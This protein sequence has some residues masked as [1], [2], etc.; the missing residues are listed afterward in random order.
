MASPF[1]L[2]TKTSET[3]E[4][5]TDRFGFQS[6]ATAGTVTPN[7]REGTTWGK[8]YATNKAAT[9]NAAN[10]LNYNVANRHYV[11]GATIFWKYVRELDDAN[12]SSFDLDVDT[13]S[14][15]TDIRIVDKVTI[16][17][18][19]WQNS[20]VDRDI[21]YTFDFLNASKNSLG[22]NTWIIGTSGYTRD[23][24]FGIDKLIKKYSINS[25]DDSKNWASSFTQ[26]IIDDLKIKVTY[27]EKGEG[28]GRAGMHALE[29]IVE[30]T[31][32]NA[33]FFG[34]VA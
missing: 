25:A 4:D 29:V 11:D 30:Y 8:M 27:N 14:I 28:A 16:N 32:D 33:L 34:S 5:F 13:G 26:S 9:F 2:I 20:G 24:T 21:S 1:T 23:T 31:T 17:A 3:T 18:I 12:S 10:I 22:L 15:P 6:T 7:T 19:V